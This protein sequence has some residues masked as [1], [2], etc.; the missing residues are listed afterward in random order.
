MLQLL[1]Y[2]ELHGIILKRF[3]NTLHWS[4]TDYWKYLEIESLD[5][6]LLKK[7]INKVGHLHKKVEPPAI[8]LIKRMDGLMDGERYH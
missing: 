8:T 7:I 1:K 5:S 2:I 3:C 6:R 4:S